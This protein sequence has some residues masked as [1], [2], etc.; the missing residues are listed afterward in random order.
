MMQ[1]KK[2]RRIVAMLVVAVAIALAVLGY[3]KTCDDNFRFS[4]YVEKHAIRTHADLTEVH[5]KTLFGKA[6]KKS[7]LIILAKLTELYEAAQS[8][9]RVRN[10]LVASHVNPR[11]RIGSSPI[12]Y[13]SYGNYRPED[14][15][16]LAL[17]YLSMAMSD[18][19]K[20]IIGYQT[21]LAGYPDIYDPKHKS[22]YWAESV[23]EWLEFADTH[24]AFLRESEQFEQSHLEKLAASG[25]KMNY[26]DLEPFHERYPHSYGII[27]N[28]SQKQRLCAGEPLFR[29]PQID[30]ILHG[31]RFWN[32]FDIDPLQKPLLE[33]RDAELAPF[34]VVETS[35]IGALQLTNGDLLRWDGSTSVKP[36]AKIIAAKA[37]GHDWKWN[38]YRENRAADVVLTESYYVLFD[39]EQGGEYN[40]HL[41]KH[42][43]EFPKFE[44]DDQVSVG[45][46]NEL[47][48]SQTHDSIVNLING[49][50]DLVF[51]T[52][53]PSPDETALAREKSVELL[54]TP[55]AKDA[56][57]FLQNRHNPVRDLTLE[58]VRDIFSGKQTHWKNVGGF[59]GK[60]NP[61]IRDRNSGSEELMR[62]LVMHNVT[63]PENFYHQLIGSMSGIFDHLD[64]DLNGIGY[65]IMYY[66][67]NMV[68]S[69]YTRTIRI[70][71]IEPNPETVASGEYPLIYECVVIRR[72]NVDEK[73]ESF[74]DWL[75]G[76]EGQSIVRESGY[77]PL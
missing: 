61:L 36:I 23:D 59:G 41:V 34:K 51:S 52:R 64:R 9:A 44:H 10:E 43:P 37:G 71:G 57:V 58:Q 75:I 40:R 39:D 8:Y 68:C 15:F 55:F 1:C 63:V 27:L 50:R 7:H 28:E 30:L 74:V 67:R 6:P 32:R 20:P 29:N 24:I 42:E 4:E 70:N 25:R 72:K 56:F 17:W 53:V 49:E 16:V 18:S 76:K 13:I 69:P 3:W 77:V 66:E 22:Q 35:E 2:H 5:Q 54:I 65:S 21:N 62:E 14:E 19:K 12:G 48:F 45:V 38:T 47:K 73:I 33:K 60:I 11:D 31:E 46:I 26:K